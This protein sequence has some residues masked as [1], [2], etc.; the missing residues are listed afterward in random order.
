MDCFLRGE[1]RA[2]GGGG[3]PP[4]A[5]TNALGRA[6]LN[7]RRTPALL[8][9]PTRGRARVRTELA[10]GPRRGEGPRAPGRREPRAPRLEAG[11]VPGDA[12]RGVAAG[13]AS[14]QLRGRAARAL[15]ATACAAARG[16]RE[17][18][19]P[20]AAG[21]AARSR[22][23][24]SPDRPGPAD[25]CGA[26]PVRRVPLRPVCSD[27]RRPAMAATDLLG[28]VDAAHLLRRAGFGPR[29]GEVEKFAAKTRRE[30]RRRAARREDPEVAAALG[31]DG[32]FDTFR[33]MQRWWLQQMRSPK[34]RLHEKMTL[35]WHDH[36]PSSYNVSD[37]P[38]LDGDPERD[39][40]A[41]T[42]SG[43]SAPRLPGDARPGDARLPR[44]LPQPRREPE[45]ELRARGDG[46]V[47]ARRRG[48]AR[49]AELHP[50]RRGPARPGAHG[51]R[52]GLQA[53]PAHRHRGALLGRLRRRG[54]DAVPGQALRGHG[55]PRR[56]GCRRQPVPANINAIDILFTHTDSAGRPTTARFISRK[57][58]EWFAYPGARPRPRRRARRRVRGGQLRAPAPGPGAA[59]ARRVLQRAG[60]DARRPSTRWTSRSR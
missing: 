44:R 38:Q 5:D 46:A 11:G 20:H 41:R 48:P 53:K 26:P 24:P 12:L 15:H 1:P 47:R 52:P 31:H 14:A 40:S 42:A 22:D 17:L 18:R 7:R 45:R 4:A 39:S 59:R 43:T 35:F 27:D 16:A 23:F 19:Q 30:R 3:V 50:G 32:D 28:D 56:R 13:A 21:A 6:T 58:W 54:E 9:A 29:P 2:D 49:R 57:L 25:R 60:D 36:F 34:W 37:R 55:Q 8:D 51:L 10:H 33:K